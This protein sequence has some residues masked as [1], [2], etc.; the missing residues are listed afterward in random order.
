MLV[1]YLKRPIQSADIEVDTDVELNNAFQSLLRM[2]AKSSHIPRD[3]LDEIN[4][5]SDT[6]KPP[7][8]TS[9]VEFTS[10]ERMAATLRIV[11]VLVALAESE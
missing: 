3:V 4:L 5:Q 2:G 11:Q 8:S 6:G 1:G 9:A 10:R 7:S